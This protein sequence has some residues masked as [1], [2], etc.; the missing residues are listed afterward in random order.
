[1]GIRIP[2]LLVCQPDYGEQAFNVMDELVRL[3]NW[4][5]LLV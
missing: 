3:N 1:V 2:E 5:D 4:F